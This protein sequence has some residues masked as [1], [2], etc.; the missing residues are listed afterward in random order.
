M[1]TV[2]FHA[3]TALP[4]TLANDSIYFVTTGTNQME[5]YVTS[6]SGAARRNK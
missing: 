4:A 2:N 3:V 1:A 6:T 5:V